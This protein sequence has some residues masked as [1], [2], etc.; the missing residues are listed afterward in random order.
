MDDERGHLVHVL[1]GHD[2]AA[3]KEAFARRR[4]RSSSGCREEVSSSFCTRASSSGLAGRVRSRLRTRVTVARM[5]AESGVKAASRWL[6]RGSRTMIGNSV[7]DQRRRDAGEHASCEP[8]ARPRSA[9]GF[10]ARSA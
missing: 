6:S 10:S 5:V 3:V 2:R 8:P 7:T 1:G 4:F 9:E